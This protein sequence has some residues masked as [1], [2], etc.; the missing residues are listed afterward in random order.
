MERDRDTQVAVPRVSV[1]IPAYN[2][3]DMLVRA[4]RSALGQT[5]HALEVLVVDDGSAEDVAGAL[6][7]IDDP[8]L[9][10]VRHATNRGA[11][12]ARNTGIERARGEFVAFLDSDDEWL[13]EK[14][15]LQ[16][17]CFDHA[18]PSIVMVYTGVKVLPDTEK[19][20]THELPRG[21]ISQAALVANDIGTTS[22]AMVRRAALQRIGGFDES[23]P[24]C[25][26]WDLY[27]R[28]A[29]IG[30]I[31]LVPELLTLYLKHDNSITKSNRASI[32]GHRRLMK[33]HAAAIAALPASLRALHYVRLMALFVWKRSWDDAAQCLSRAVAADPRILSYVWDF[34]VMRSLR[35]VIWRVRRIR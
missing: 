12:A 24:S 28:L 11:S 6:A 22:A 3:L 4:V 30:S 21:D 18:D 17:A 16:V 19:Q 1:V 25:Q 13:P 33:K 26:D 35:R 29:E 2:R 23:L 15:A 10:V 14:T 9:V 34:L 7:G 32:L 8:R 31:E 20:R 27:I 5:F